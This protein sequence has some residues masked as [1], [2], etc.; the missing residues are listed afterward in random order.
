MVMWEIYGKD[1]NAVAVQTTVEGIASNVNPSVLSGH[2]L[3]FK[4]VTYNNADEVLG[5]LK[6]EDCFFIK[7]CHFLFEKEVRISLDT[8]SSYNPTK[9]TPY[10]Y[11]L[12]EFLNRMI[13]KVV[14]HPDSLDWFFDVVDSVSKKYS[15]HAPVEIGV[16]GNN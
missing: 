11:K 12:P 4:D 5:V 10:G 14:V 9:N 6:Y 16:C 7:R 15:L 2:S 13:D 1:K 3:I 8:Y